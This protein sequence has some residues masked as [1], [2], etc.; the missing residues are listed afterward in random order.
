MDELTLLR[1]FRGSAPA[2]APPA[3]R[4]RVLAGPTRR[5]PRLPRR[6]S[7]FASGGVVLAATAT[8]FALS[9][10]PSA[11]PSAATVLHRAAD[12]VMMA[13]PVPTPRADQ[14]IYHQSVQADLET[15]QPGT[16]PADYWVRVD[17]RQVAVR[18]PNGKINVNATVSNPLGAP[19]QWYDLAKELPAAPQGVLDMLTRDPLYTSHASTRAARDFDE[20]TTALTSDS[21]LPPESIARLYGALATIPGVS[22]DRDAPAD[23]FGRPVLSITYDGDSSLGRPGDRWELLLDPDSYRVIGLRGTAGHEFDLKDGTV[24]PA[25]T[26]WVNLALLAEG[27]VDEPGQLL[28]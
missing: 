9:V 21:V 14:W 19:I 3:V 22:A 7:A 25:G 17:G 23:L 5:R 12:H 15:G 27:V 13:A 24:I 1:E 10:G 18:L 11:P 4:R 2:A 26:V 16:L 28:D 20:V 6:L 8:V